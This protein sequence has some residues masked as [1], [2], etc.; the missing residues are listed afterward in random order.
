MNFW[1]HL[2]H[3]NR[4]ISEICLRFFYRCLQYFQDS[5]KQNC[6][7]KQYHLWLSIKIPLFLQNL[8]YCSL[9]LILRKY[10]TLLS[11]K[12][13]HIL[14]KNYQNIF[15]YSKAIAIFFT[16]CFSFHWK[17]FCFSKR[18]KRHFNYRYFPEVAAF[19]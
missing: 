7:I 1:C 19:L 3:L 5:T 16:I 17:C 2:P 11:E 12:I 14:K 10:I 6:K 18:C 9:H 13:C 4:R 8:P 15:M